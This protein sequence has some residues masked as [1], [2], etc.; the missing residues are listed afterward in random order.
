MKR[1]TSNVFP[2]WL[3]AMQSGD[4]FFS[5]G[6]ITQTR[7]ASGRGSNR[8]DHVI[9]AAGNAL[10]MHDRVRGTFDLVGGYSTEARMFYAF[11]DI[12]ANLFDPSWVSMKWTRR[13]EVPA[14]ARLWGATHQ[15]YQSGSKLAA[16]SASNNGDL[17]LLELQRGTV[18]KVLAKVLA[19][20]AP[21]TGLAYG[22]AKAYTMAGSNGFANLLLGQ[23]AIQRQEEFKGVSDRVAL[24]RVLSRFEPSDLDLFKD[25][26]LGFPPDDDILPE[27]VAVT[28]ATT[29]Y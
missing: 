9:E 19:N 8:S 1:D 6:E 5:G 17:P 4:L 15:V 3:A 21:G 25:L 11:Q 27:V 24:V 2:E 23:L 29:I 18:A 14:P 20:R 10:L 22:V 16:L 13:V 28:D 7:Q 12:D 26:P